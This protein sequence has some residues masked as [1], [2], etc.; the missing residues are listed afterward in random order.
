MSVETP[1]TGVC[2]LDD[3]GFCFGCYRN[4][5]EIQT[6]PHLDDEEKK[7]IITRL[8]ETE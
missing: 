7:I 1:C 6:W 3:N 4:V 5:D 8:E 2:E